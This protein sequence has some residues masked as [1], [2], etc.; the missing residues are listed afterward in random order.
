MGNPGHRSPFLRLLVHFG[1]PCVVSGLAGWAL[2][3]SVLQS[4]TFVLSLILF[5]H[6]LSGILDWGGYEFLNNL[7]VGFAALL[8]FAAMLWIS[9]FCRWVGGVYYTGLDCHPT[10]Q[11]LR[12]GLFSHPRF[13]S[14][15][16][17]VLPI[18]PF[19]KDWLVALFERRKAESGPR[20]KGDSDTS[21]L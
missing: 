1:A 4:L 13:V 3:W 12:G 16:M 17:T 19:L 11:E 18:S 21:N 8:L 20:E 9:F 6:W 14:I 2:E 10:E 7:W 15:A 5:T